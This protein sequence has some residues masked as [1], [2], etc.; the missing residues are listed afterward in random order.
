MSCDLDQTSKSAN[1]PAPMREGMLYTLLLS[2]AKLV[3]I[4]DET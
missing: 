4:I 1:R 2:R 3:C